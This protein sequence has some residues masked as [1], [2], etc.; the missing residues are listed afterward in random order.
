MAMTSALC[1]RPK[2]AEHSRRALG[3]VQVSEEQLQ[4]GCR[5]VWVCLGGGQGG[6]LD[7]P[8]RRGGSWRFITALRI[9]P[10]GNLVEDAAGSHRQQPHLPRSIQTILLRRR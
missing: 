9:F 3:I 5:P 7:C 2:L 4:R 8:T 1:R 10:P 6:S